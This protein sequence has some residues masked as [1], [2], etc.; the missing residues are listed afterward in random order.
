MEERKFFFFFFL[1]GA[2]D[3]EKESLSFIEGEVYV[4]RL[5]GWS[6]MLVSI[7]KDGRESSSVPGRE[8]HPSK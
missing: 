7:L 4:G 1:A 5:D 6:V 3:G 2:F 8:P